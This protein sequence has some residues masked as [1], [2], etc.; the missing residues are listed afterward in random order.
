V[1]RKAAPF[2]PRRQL[3]RGSEDLAGRLEREV[4]KFIAMTDTKARSLHAVT[5]GN[6]S[7]I[8]AQCEITLCR[9]FRRLVSV[10]LRVAHSVFVSTRGNVLANTNPLSVF[11]HFHNRAC[12]AITPH[13]DCRAHADGWNF[14][15]ATTNKMIDEGACL[16]SK[17]Q[18]GF[19]CCIHS[20]AFHF[21][22]LT[23]VR[24]LADALNVRSFHEVGKHYFSCF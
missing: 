10:V 5:F 11:G 22:G 23:P 7:A 17:V 15:R 16:C 18:S 12:V 21:P 19:D 3:E 6:P 1:K 14:V 4:V 13:Q 2:R 9:A 8:P 20:V 24:F